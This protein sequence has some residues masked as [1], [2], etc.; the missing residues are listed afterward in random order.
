MQAAR[1]V[2]D[3][4]RTTEKNAE[5]R[6]WML[7]VEEHFGILLAALKGTRALK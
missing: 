7:I 6:P 2:E 5:R 1:C 4:L 3:L